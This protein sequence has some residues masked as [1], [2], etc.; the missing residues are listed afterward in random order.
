M[1]KL[2]S[3]WGSGGMADAT[4]LKSV[5]SSTVWVRLPPALF[6]CLWGGLFIQYHFSKIVETRELTETRLEATTQI[7]TYELLQGL[8]TQSYIGINPLKS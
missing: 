4:D 1:V 8:P 7:R 6:F 3:V 2:W 5:G